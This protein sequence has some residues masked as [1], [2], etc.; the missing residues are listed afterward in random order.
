M[1]PGNLF[2]EK[3]T[4]GSAFIYFLISGI[5]LYKYGIQLGGEAEKYIDN[6]NR[7]I[8]HD[9]LRNGFFG[10]F[11]FA[12][13]LIISF[14]I[15]F[16][17]NLFF[18]AVLQII[19][20]FVAAL[21]LYKMALLVLENKTIAFCIFC[22]YL[23]C[24]PIQKWNFFL[25]SESIH[26]SLV[27]IAAYLFCKAINE[28]KYRQWIN[29]GF[30]TLVVIFSRPV[31]IIFLVSA[32][33]VLIV[34]LYRNKNGTGALVLGLLLLAGVIGI[35]NSPVSSFINPDSL[36]RMEVICQ[37]PEA[38]ANINYTEFNKEGLYKAYTVIKDEIGV[39]NFILTG[40]KKLSSFYS[41]YRPYYSW[42]NNLLL[43]LYCIFYPFAFVAI[44]SKQPNSFWYIKLLSILYIGLTSI[45]IFF[46]CDDWAN[47]FIS[48]VFPFVLILA[49][50]AIR[51]LFYKIKLWR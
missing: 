22:C 6:A 42:Q 50:P 21:A 43:L 31:G 26:T 37:V 14:F 45:I 18:V 47:R 23:I 25:Y 4:I 20:C 5:F 44:F 12:Y 46:T 15:R 38:N 10:I 40:F 9:E 30:I 36:R 19:I 41:Q 35:A 33:L 1:R 3:K 34:W 49:A 39:G 11:Y 29:F 32:S 51:N 8:R 2:F 24:Y 13:S 16:S 28:N 48:P 17:I 7:I 27:V